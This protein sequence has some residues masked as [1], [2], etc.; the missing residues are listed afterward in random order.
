LYQAF[1]LLSAKGLTHKDFQ[2]CASAPNIFIKKQAG[3]QGKGKELSA[4][5]QGQAFLS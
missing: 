4:Q 2:S 1:F 3:K 5:K